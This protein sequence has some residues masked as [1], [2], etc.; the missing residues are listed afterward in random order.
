MQLYFETE[1]L[2][3]QV[4][5]V[6]AAPMVLDFYM[7]NRLDFE[8]WDPVHIPDFY[9][10]SYQQQALAAEHR[11]ML[12]RRGIRFYVFLKSSPAVIIGSVSFAHLTPCNGQFCRIGYKL[13]KEYR[14]FGYAYEMLNTLIPYIKKEFS[15][16]CIEADI[17]PDNAASISLISKLG[18]E[19]DAIPVFLEAGPDSEARKAHIRYFLH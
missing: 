19:I 3:I 4:L 17:Q 9:T 10:L 7:R 18:F 2:E 15:L 1:R 6:S 16:S 12:T 14:R 8:N 5:D 13:D 11:L